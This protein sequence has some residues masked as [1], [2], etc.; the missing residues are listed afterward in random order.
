MDG[1]TPWQSI[2]SDDWFCHQ[3][4]FYPIF[5][6]LK[7]ITLSSLNTVSVSECFLKEA[8]LVLLLNLK[9]NKW[10]F[11]N[12]WI[13]KNGFLIPLEWMGLLQGQGLNTRRWF[14]PVAEL[15]IQFTISISINVIEQYILS[16]TN[17]KQPH[18]RKIPNPIHNLSIVLSVST[19]PVNLEV[20]KNLNKWK[21]QDRWKRCQQL[22][23]LEEW[24]LSHVT[25]QQQI[26][27]YDHRL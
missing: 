3:R 22:Q 23:L 9:D 21:P 18:S 27:T 10:I 16:L 2:P 8:Q 25:V 26:L 1:A 19:T 13:L 12:K 15:K 17:L 14:N 24:M 7:E 6:P 20:H 4:I 11:L 5:S